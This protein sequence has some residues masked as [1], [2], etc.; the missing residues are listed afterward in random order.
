MDKLL[1]KAMADA[2]IKSAKQLSEISGCSYEQTRNALAGKDVKL[3]AIAK[4]F[5]A[6]GFKLKYVSKG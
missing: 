3:V 2:G 4:M 1:K 6:M 5:D